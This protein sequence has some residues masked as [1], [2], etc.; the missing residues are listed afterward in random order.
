MNNI[1]YIITNGLHTLIQRT[2]EVKL[3]LGILSLL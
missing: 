1:K 3:N 2:D